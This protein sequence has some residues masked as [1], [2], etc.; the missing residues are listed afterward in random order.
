MTNFFNRRQNKITS[1]ITSAFTAAFNFHWYNYFSDNQNPN[2]IINNKETNKLSLNQTLQYPASFD[3]R[4]VIY[5]TENTLMDYLKW[6]Q[7]D[8]HINNLHNTTFYALTREYTKYIKMD[9]KFHIEFPYIGPKFEIQPFTAVEATKKLSGTLS[10]D[11]NEILFTDY[12]INYNNELE[13]FRKGTII[14]VNPEKSLVQQMVKKL[15]ITGK[16]KK[17][18]VEESIDENDLI[19]DH[20]SESI[21]LDLFQML[22]I[23]IISDQFWQKYGK[24]LMKL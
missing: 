3:G 6:R 9:D 17:N 11:K 21:S 24:I 2:L 23:D 18:N 5:P 20:K 22:N 4:S 1:L 16:S 8:C 13:Q 12:G 10:S 15:S 14:F 7:A 19:D